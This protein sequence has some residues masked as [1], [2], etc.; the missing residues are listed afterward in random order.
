M[1]TPDLQINQ[2]PITRSPYVKFL[3]L[4]VDEALTWKQHI[5]LVCKKVSTNIGI[6]ARSKHLLTQKQLVLLYNA[7]V[8]PHINYCLL[9]WGV[10]YSTYLD[11]ITILQKRM[12]RVIMGIPLREHTAPHFK[13]LEILKVSDLVKMQSIYF[14]YKFLKNLLPFELHNIFSIRLP[15]RFTRNKDA[16]E[17]PFTKKNFRLHTLR[18]FAPPLWNHISFQNKIDTSISI[19][20]LK[21]QLKAHFLSQYSDSE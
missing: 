14:T 11:K 7:L 1:S 15:T 13:S 4:T 12:V 6:I 19:I 5:S 8:L 20:T 3:G 10:N 18:F 17:I 9:V 21:K 2:I 16:L